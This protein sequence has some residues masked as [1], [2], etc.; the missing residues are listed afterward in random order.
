MKTNLKLIT[1][2]IFMSAGLTADCLIISSPAT[3]LKKIGGVD[4]RAQ[5]IS[6]V[7]YDEKNKMQIKG[8]AD[9][10][11]QFFTTTTKNI[12]ADCKKYNIS[13]IYNFKVES[14]TDENYYYFNATYDF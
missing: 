1:L 2:G 5:A 13:N 7:Y 9:A 6:K 11:V 4:A 12:Q 14:S 8:Y 10:Y 3:D